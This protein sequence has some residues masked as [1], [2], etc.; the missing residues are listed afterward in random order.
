MYKDSHCSSAIPRKC[1]LYNL[2]D[3]NPAAVAKTMET[4]ALTQVSGK[5]SESS[6]LF[7]QRN[8]QSVAS[9]NPL[10]SFSFGI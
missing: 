2:W 4:C 8:F 10:F 1:C 7:T 6:L 9:G 3:F 5:Y